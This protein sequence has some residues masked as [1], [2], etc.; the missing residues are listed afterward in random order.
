MA[1]RDSA[2]G[3]NGVD[4]SYQIAVRLHAPG[5]EEQKMQKHEKR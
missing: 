4:I 1:Q 5:M 3:V 2:S